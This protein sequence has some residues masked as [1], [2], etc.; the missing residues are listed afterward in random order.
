MIQ[1]TD[2]KG[3]AI[4]MTLGFLKNK[5][6]TLFSPLTEKKY[7][8]NALPHSKED[9]IRDENEKC[10]GNICYISPRIIVPNPSQPRTFFDNTEIVRL[11]DSIKQFGII[12][13]LSVR[14]SEGGKYEL[15][16]GERRLRA[17][18]LLGLQ[19]VPCIVMSVSREC[20]A[21][22]AIIENLQR[23]NLNIFEQGYAIEKLM[24]LYNYT[25]AEVALKLIT[26]PVC[27]CK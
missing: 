18:K 22:L 13:P 15:I 4:I 16:A 8:K 20:S 14:I 27:R 7:C 17:S 6:G 2:K 24:K 11:A 1:K 9:T 21:E 25:Q 23:E 26:Q 5:S 19:Q 12:Q 3:K 10:G